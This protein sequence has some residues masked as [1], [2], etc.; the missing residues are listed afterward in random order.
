M[1]LLFACRVRKRKGSSDASAAGGGEPRQQGA[2][3]GGKGWMLPLRIDL[4]QGDEHKGAP[5][6]LGVWQDQTPGHQALKTAPGPA[7]LPAAKIEDVDVET[8][9]APARAEAATGAAFEALHEPQQGRRAQV[10]G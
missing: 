10:C 6:D 7:K 1:S 8:A 4:E 3:S 5:V 9:R 2:P